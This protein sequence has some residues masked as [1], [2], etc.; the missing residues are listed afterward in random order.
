MPIDVITLGETM[1]RL[2][3]RDQQLIEQAAQFEI[4]VGGSES[5]VA[6]GLARLG[7]HVRWLSRLTDNPLGRRIAGAISAHGVDTSQVVWTPED[8]VGMYY[9]EEGPPPRG[10]R[11]TYDRAASAMSRMQPDD[12][13]GDLFDEDHAGWL[14]VSGIT[15]AIGPSAAATVT[16][17]VEQAKSAG[18]RVSFD[19]NHRALLW[20]DEEATVA[21]A[22]VMAQ[23]DLI[24]IALRDAVRLFNTPATYEA[25]L[26]TLQSRF[27]EAPIVVTMGKDGAGAI[28]VGSDRVHHQ[29]TFPAQGSGRIGGGDAFAAGFL[30]RYME[31]ATLDDAL[32]WGAAAAAYKYTLPGDLPLLDRGTLQAILDG[33]DGLRR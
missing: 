28:N 23:A 9:V 10:G 19:V 5:N 13:P 33:T 32:A 20:T 4:Y 31:T 16:Q 24:M 8:R 22:A 6:V 25:A 15:L 18:W 14:H 11:V 27:P 7:W 3:P 1:L 30:S 26:K 12:L 21:C 2:T 17:A 29:P